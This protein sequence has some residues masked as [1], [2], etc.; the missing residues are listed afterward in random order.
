MCKVE[1]VER[2]VKA[3]FNCLD[4]VWEQVS[5]KEEFGLEGWASFSWSMLWDVVQP[6]SPSKGQRSKLLN[7]LSARTNFNST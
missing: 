6:W 2:L 5:G 7:Q 1:G 3:C 4:I